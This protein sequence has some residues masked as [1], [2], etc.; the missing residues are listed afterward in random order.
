[1]DTKDEQRARAKE[2]LE[3]VGI[4]N[5]SCS[6]DE[7]KSMD[8]ER[9]LK[10]GIVRGMNDKWINSGL[11]DM[12]VDEKRYFVSF[13]RDDGSIEIDFSGNLDDIERTKKEHL[14]SIDKGILCEYE[15]KIELLQ[16]RADHLERMIEYKNEHIDSLK[17]VIS[18]YEMLSKSKIK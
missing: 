4:E 3:S 17:E 11:G 7:V 6:P 1:M 5:E 13:I 16:A 2:Y 8:L 18:I 9:R 15:H 14:L 10:S 12:Y